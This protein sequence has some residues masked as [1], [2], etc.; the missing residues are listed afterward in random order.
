MIGKKNLVF[1][2]ILL[3]LCLLD[4]NIGYVNFPCPKILLRVLFIFFLNLAK[5]FSQ[6]GKMYRVY[7]T[8][9]QTSFGFHM[10]RLLW[11]TWDEQCLLKITFGSGEDDVLIHK[12]R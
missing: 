5:Y 1:L 4:V 6:Q 3:Y 7:V 12:G 10:P 2:Y 11:V 8:S 9:T